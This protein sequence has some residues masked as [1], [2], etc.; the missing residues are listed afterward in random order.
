MN[1]KEFSCKQL[2][3]IELLAAAE[4]NQGRICEII[5]VSRPTLQKWRRQRSFV[6]AVIERSR[7]LIRE[8]LPQLYK[9]A[10][11]NALDGKHSYFKTLLEHVDRIEA[12]A[13]SN[14]ERSIT[15]TWNTSNPTVDGET[16]IISNDNLEDN[17]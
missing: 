11:E 10:V 1:K 6:D 4:H 13:K 16:G 9:S 2:R 12:L 7:E 14:T 3:A 5:N 17:T 15:F 8:H